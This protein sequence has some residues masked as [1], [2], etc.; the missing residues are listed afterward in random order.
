MR[1]WNCSTAHGGVGRGGVGG[2]GAAGAQQR[3][4]VGGGALQVST[5]H[6][7]AHQR[8]GGGATRLGALQHA[9]GRQR[10]RRRPWKWGCLTTG[11]CPS[12]PSLLMP[13]RKFSAWIIS[14]SR[15]FLRSLVGRSCGGRWAP[16]GQVTG[17]GAAAEGGGRPGGR[18]AGAARGG[19]VH[20]AAAA[21][22]PLLGRSAA[23]T[24]LALR[25][26][27]D[28]LMRTPPPRSSWHVPAHLL[29]ERGVVGCA[30]CGLLPRGAVHH[31]PT[32]GGQRHSHGHAPAAPLHAACAQAPLR[33]GRGGCMGGA[34][35]CDATTCMPPAPIDRALAPWRAGSLHPRPLSTLKYIPL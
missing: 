32:A 11:P 20:Q 1:A 6:Q 31:A 12:G 34:S 29:V 17:G 19:A 22:A 13:F 16:G 23:A 28:S 3:V 5:R 10:A 15:V 21:H 7:D 30:G 24:G 26:G 8:R 9:G 35:G 2:G 33:Q 4:G 18:W 25:M 27:S 14:C